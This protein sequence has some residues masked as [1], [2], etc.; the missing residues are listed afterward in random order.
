[1]NGMSRGG[2][3]PKF[4]KKNDEVAI[5]ALYK[6]GFGGGSNIFNNVNIGFFAAHG[7]FGS[8]LDHTSEAFQTYQTYFPIW[9]S[10]NN[11]TEWMRLSEFDFG[12]PGTVGLRWMAILACNALRDD[13][14]V[15][16]YNRGVLPINDDLHLLCSATTYSYA[17]DDLGAIWAKQMTSG[18][19]FA[20]PQTVKRAWFLGGSLGYKGETGIT[21]TVIFRVAGWPN[22]FSDKLLNYAASTDSPDPSHITFED[23]QVWPTV[24]VP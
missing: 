8:T 22:C 6:Q 11:T 17:A 18:G 13:N 21:N 10:A 1:V 19:A 16:M 4:I 2:W 23:Q 12:S 24:P 7:N 20:P 15:S 5:Q 3:K 14:Y 9:N